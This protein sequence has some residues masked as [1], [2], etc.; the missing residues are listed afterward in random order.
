MKDMIKMALV[1]LTLLMTDSSAASKVERYVSNDLAYSDEKLG[2][3][4]RYAFAKKLA[5][6]ARELQVV[7]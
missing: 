5:R 4:N 2:I 3:A 7:D 1:I 6:F